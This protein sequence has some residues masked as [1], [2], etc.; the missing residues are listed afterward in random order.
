MRIITRTLGYDPYTLCIEEHL[1]DEHRGK[2]YKI[3]ELTVH[4]GFNLLAKHR[5]KTLEECIEKAAFHYGVPKDYWQYADVYDSASVHDKE[6]RYGKRDVYI[7]DEYKLTR[8][9]REALAFDYVVAPYLRKHKKAL[10]TILGTLIVIWLFILV[11]ALTNKAGEETPEETTTTPMEYSEDLEI[12]EQPQHGRTLLYYKL[13]D[14]ITRVDT[15][16]L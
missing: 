16:G 15:I 1:T 8:R 5:A 6:K 13:G 10:V 3:C 12:V 14:S 11:Y 7:E 9:H 2:Q 4:Q